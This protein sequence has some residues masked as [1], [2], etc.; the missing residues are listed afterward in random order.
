MT[1]VRA[2]IDIDN[3]P[4]VQYLLPFKREFE[5]AGLETLVTARDHTST[6]EQLRS[7]DVDFHAVG[8]AFG[9]SKLRK[10]AGVLERSRALAALLSDWGRPDLLVCSSRSSALTAWR[11]GIPGFAIVDYEFVDLRIFRLARTHIVFPGVIG[12]AAFSRRGIRHDRLLPFA[13]LKEDISFSGVEVAGVAP[14]RFDGD[15]DPLPKLLLR[16]PA[17]ES[18]YYRTTTGVLM[19]ELLHHLAEREELVVV[20]SPRYE[21]QAEY[22]DRFTWRKRPIVL[23]RPVPFVALLKSV[24]AVVSSGGTMLREAAYL[25]VPSF[26]VFGGEIGAVDKYLESI[27]SVTVIRSPADFSRLQL[28]KTAAAPRRNPGVAHDLTETLLRR[29][30]QCRS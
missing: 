26:S 24:G 21:W 11:L 14:H 27:G 5:E 13:G 29:A 17:E 9:R 4:Q 10:V 28:G 22:L 25:G 3:P 19:M 6:L 23:R 1:S 15:R 18:H 12:A 20:F 8:A 7:R 2:W 30:E 16:P